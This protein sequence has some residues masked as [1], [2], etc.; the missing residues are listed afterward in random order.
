M[1]PELLLTVEKP[2]DVEADIP[3]QSWHANRDRLGGQ[4]FEP[5]LS[6]EDKLQFVLVQG[7]SP[8]SR[9]S[10]RKASCPVRHRRMERRIPGARAGV[11]T[12]TCDSHGSRDGQAAPGIEANRSPGDPAIGSFVIDLVHRKTGFRGAL[13]NPCALVANSSNHADDA[14]IMRFSLD[15]L[16]TVRIHA[17]SDVRRAAQALRDAAPAIIEGLIGASHNIASSRPMVDADGNV[18][19]T[20]VF[21]WPDGA[22]CWWRRPETAFD[23][24]LPMACRYESEPFWCNGEGIHATRPNPFLSGIDLSEFERRTSMTAAIVAPAHLPFG[25]IGAVLISPRDRTHTDLSQ[26]FEAHGALFRPLRPD[27]SRRLRGCDD[28][29]PAASI[30]APAPKA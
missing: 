18:L 9:R 5:A 22:G 29:S 3:D 26:E 19:A 10:A 12:S 28:A 15:H 30:A 24:P 17:P 1:K 27:L 13:E 7:I 20:D 21:G 4:R 11:R 23:S 16:H 6:L 2:L 25:Q 14:C 8:K